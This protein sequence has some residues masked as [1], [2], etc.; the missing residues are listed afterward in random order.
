ME[1]IKIEIFAQLIIFWPILIDISVRFLVLKLIFVFQRNI[2]NDLNIVFLNFSI[3]SKVNV[4]WLIESV[5]R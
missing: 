4:E 5:I 2:F 3:F 1:F